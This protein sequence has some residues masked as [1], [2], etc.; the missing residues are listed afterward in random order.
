MLGAESF[1][2]VLTEGL[3][4]GEG[5]KQAKDVKKAYGSYLAFIGLCLGGFG[6]GFLGGL[7][8]WSYYAISMLDFPTVLGS[9]GVDCHDIIH[10]INSMQ[11]PPDDF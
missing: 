5:E 8:F 11:N 3:E 4:T 9:L 7:G 6:G 10:L 2:E 1:Q